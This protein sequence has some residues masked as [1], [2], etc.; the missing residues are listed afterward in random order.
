MT[1]DEAQ[2][3]NP[4][5]LGHLVSTSARQGVEAGEDIV[6]ASGLKLL[7]KGAR[8]Q[9]EVV[10]RLLQHKLARPLEQSLQVVG[11]VSAERLGSLASEMAGRHALLRAVG[12]TAEGQGLPAALAALPLSAPVRSLLSVLDQARPQGLEHALGAAMIALWLAR[13][14]LPGEPA[15]HAT[16]ALAGLLHDVG[17]LYIDPD[18]LR[19]GQRLS[20]ARWRHIVVHPLLAHHVLNRLPGA[21]AAVA[22]VVLLHHERLDGFGYPR[23]ISGT[24]FTL[25]G[26]ALAAADALMAILASRDSPLTRAS[27]AWR[28]IP[29]EFDPAVLAAVESAAREAGEVPP[30]LDSAPP[31]SDAVRRIERVA[32]TLRRF[33]ASLDWIDA[34]I[35]DGPP[36]LSAVLQ[37]GT[38]RMRRIRS[39]F[40]STGLD[41]QDAARVLADLSA[42]GDPRVYV[43]LMSLVGELE[44]R[45]RELERAQQMRASLLPEQSQVVIGQL[46]RRLRSPDAPAG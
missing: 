45:L 30:L 19:P 21:G 20:P 25:D 31:L 44:W 32:A 26:Q 37:A 16:I 46:I 34:R 12:A 23:G 29:G 3:A 13:R 10:E 8:L 28:L 35:A 18:C 5:Y 14:L 9:A 17:E 7:A 11:A 22:A 15:R 6:S 27:M 24:A 39:S 41:T 43:E 40:S 42:L 1:G 4:H 2:A 33:D 36:E 38:S